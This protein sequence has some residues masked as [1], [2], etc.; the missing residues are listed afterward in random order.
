MRPAF[1]KGRCPPATTLPFRRVPTRSQGRRR[2]R[3]MYLERTGMQPSAEKAATLSVFPVSP[4][5]PRDLPRRIQIT[6]GTLSLVAKGFGTLE[7]IA[8][9]PGVY[10]AR[11]ESAQKPFEQMVFL[12]PGQEVSVS[13]PVNSGETLASAAPVPG[14][15]AMHE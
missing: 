12:A 9:P 14:S 6:D 5:G 10:Q 2:S 7:R 4:I 8:L 11:V 1:L 15:D 13:Y 3:S